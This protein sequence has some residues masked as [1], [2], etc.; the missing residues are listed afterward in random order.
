MSQCQFCQMQ[1][2]QPGTNCSHCGRPIPE[3]KPTFTEAED[4]EEQPESV[5]EGPEET[6]EA[7]QDS[8]EAGEAPAEEEVVPEDGHVDNVGDASET[9]TIVP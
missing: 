9:E 3:L 2:Q 4:A 8:T 7:P 6:E 1:D 5:S